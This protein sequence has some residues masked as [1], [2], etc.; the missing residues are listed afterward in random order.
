MMS[1]PN[2]TPA[3]PVPTTATPPAPVPS[4][5]AAPPEVRAVRA[6][7]LHDLRGGAR[8]DPGGVHDLD[9]SLQHQRTTE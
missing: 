4:Y 1:D 7:A 8:V 9:V 5:D 6:G 3:V 2:P